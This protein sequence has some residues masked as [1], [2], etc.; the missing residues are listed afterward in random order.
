VH[1]NL[2]ARLFSGKMLAMQIGAVLGGV[3]AY[4]LLRDVAEVDEP[5]LQA[6]LNR[7]VDATWPIAHPSNHSTRMLHQS[8][9]PNT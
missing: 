8:L 3:F 6:S 7:L 4:Q 9:G 1:V 2:L 5:A